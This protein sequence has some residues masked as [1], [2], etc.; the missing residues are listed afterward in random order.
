MNSATLS[1]LGS[2]S[3]GLVLASLQGAKPPRISGGSQLPSAEAPT[4][5]FDILDNVEGDDIDL[6]P[7]PVKPLAVFP[8]HLGFWAL[9]THNSQVLAFGNLSGQPTQVFGVPWGPVSLE[10]W[11]S[12]LDAHEELLVVT[13]ST[14]G[15]T[16]LDPTDGS[17]LGYV[18]LPS[19]PGGTQLVGD[20]LFVACSSEDLV[21]EVD[22]LSGTIFDTYSIDT[23]RHLLFLSADGLGNVLVTP[24]LSGNNTMPKRSAVAGPNQSDPDGTVLD[25]SDPAVAD[26]G[27][28]DE[29]IFRLIPGATPN[30]GRVEVAAKG[31]GTM[32]FAH[33]LNPVG[34]KLWVLNT[35]S[36]NA[37]AVL[38]SEPEVRGLFSVNR[39]T[40][41]TLPAPGAPAATSHVFKSLDDIPTDPIGKP[42]ALAFGPAGTVIVVGALTDNVTILSSAG[43]QVVQLNLPTG[44][45][46]RGVVYD[47]QAGAVLVYCW[48]TNKVR[49]YTLSGTQLVFDLGYDPT[50]AKR[51]AGR[52]I[53]YDGHR[54][55]KQNLSCE[56]CH[57]EG[58]FDH[59]VWNLS[60]PLADDKGVLFTQSLK[61]LEFTNPYHWRG[62]R[63]L[64]DFNPAFDGLLGGAQLT[65]QEFE[66][67]EEFVFGLQ[68]PANP[69]EHPSRVVTDDRAITSFDFPTHAKL[70]AIKGQRIYFDKPT[71]GSGTCQDCH[72]LPTGTDNDF[73]PDGLKDTGHRNTFDNPAYNGMWR[74]EQKTRVTVKEVGEAPELRAPLGA[75]SSHSGLEE[76]VFEFNVDDGFT[77]P[78]QDREDVAHFVHQIDQG[79]APAVHRAG[80][81]SQESLDPAFF[82]TYLIP[83][84]KQRNCDIAVIGEVNFGAGVK[85]LRW[86][87]D[88]GT[89]LFRSED[90]LLVQRPFSFFLQQALAG[91]GRNLFV[92]LPVGMGRRFAID[93]D[94]DLLFRADELR[95]GANPLV[96]DSDNDGFLDGTEVAF[97]G[98]PTNPTVV[99]TNLQAPTITS[100]REMFHT[101]RVAKLLVETNVPTKIEVDYD[102]NLGDVGFFEEK[103]EYK[104]LWEVALR[105]LQPSN[106]VAGIS[107]IYQGTI[108]V[109]DEFGHQTQT[110][111]P[112]IET[113]PFVSALEVGVANPVLIEAVVRQLQTTLVQPATLP[114]TGWNF[115]FVAT[116]ES[117]KLD[118]P[119]YLPVHVA[120]AR[121]IVNGQIESNILVN[122]G[123][124]AT[125]IRHQQGN[126]GLY[127]GYGGSG[128]FVVG[129]I[130]GLNGQSTIS[131]NLPNAQSG[132]QVRIAIE[133]VGNPVDPFNFDPTDPWF[134][135]RTS[136]DLPSTPA[137]CRASAVITLP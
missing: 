8:N 88:R 28:P 98:N 10:H 33:G 46:P 74:K 61:G 58:V 57:V 56:S 132:D 27:L 105:D 93:E 12:P 89:G 131:F 69:F 124:P 9:N 97:G 63:E 114:A 36:I 116:L 11:V 42:Y 72:T 39:V 2:L 102:S 62:E 19:E 120:V 104:T 26:I 122:G 92:G 81:L 65:A 134:H 78:L 109:F 73:F 60:D 136:Y 91:T 125:Q 75:G 22:L 87:W 43:T 103:D 80:L 108:R 13:R 111:M 1:L 121:V 68:N 24:M 95:L 94:N 107:R 59:L 64:I 66:A 29:D 21:V 32:L 49:A 126:N 30:T 127:G 117:R 55:L 130:S 96:P 118:S 3:T 82:V 119:A 38:N 23:T 53:F 50:S 51:K 85:R 77:I 4:A 83:Q 7:F 70:S 35:E 79:L 99:P 44:S 52:E 48:G 17:I 129:S 71:I 16:R 110:A 54:S 31:V 100:V 135:R 45:I 133:L 115:S 41:V 20:H 90:S 123:P 86:T 34:G 84:A 128:P 47:A 113:L 6:L 101:A 40:L 25:M 106:S 5:P 18:Q 14:Y 112:Q 37:D 76:G 137:N 67:F 15:L